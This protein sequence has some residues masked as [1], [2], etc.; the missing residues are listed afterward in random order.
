M[1]FADAVQPVVT[2]LALVNGALAWVAKIKWSKEYAKA[3]DAEIAAKN[4]VIEAKE[5]QIA[6]LLQ[7]IELIKDFNPA[8]IREYYLAS[9]A[10]YEEN[11]KKLDSQIQ[12]LRADIEDKEKQI[13][14]LQSEGKTQEAN[15]AIL[16]LDKAQKQEAM[17]AQITRDLAILKRKTEELDP[18]HEFQ[19]RL[20]APVVPALGSLTSIYQEA[21]VTGKPVKLGSMIV[22]DEK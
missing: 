13:D 2:I 8:K 22:T 10:A 19:N 3:R 14:H 1:N 21:I 4:A 6:G 17:F 15:L 16:E 20:G 12:A 11:I 5:T 18:L 9:Q 7:Q